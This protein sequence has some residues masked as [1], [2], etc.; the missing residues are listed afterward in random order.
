MSVTEPDQQR[1]ISGGC[2]PWHQHA[3]PGQHGHQVQF[4]RQRRRGMIT[5]SVQAQGVGAKGSLNPEHHILA[6]HQ[7]VRRS[8]DLRPMGGGPHGKGQGP[9]H[10]P[11]NTWRSGSIT[12]SASATPKGIGGRI[13][14]TL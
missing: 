11:L 5:R 7:Q 1:P 8:G 6:L 9:G 3:L 13:L 2:G 10:S 14:S 4:G 12:R